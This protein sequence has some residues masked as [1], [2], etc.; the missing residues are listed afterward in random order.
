MEDRIRGQARDAALGP[1]DLAANGSGAPAG[2]AIPL[3]TVCHGEPDTVP[4][5]VTG[6]SQKCGESAHFFDLAKKSAAPIDVLFM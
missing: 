6:L 5:A 2:V 1:F 3:P 4:A